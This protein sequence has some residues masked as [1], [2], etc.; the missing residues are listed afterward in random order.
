MCH[1]TKRAKS[2][3]A[4]KHFSILDDEFNRIWATVN[5]PVVEQP[6][7]STEDRSSPMTT[8]QNNDVSE[9]KISVSLDFVIRKHHRQM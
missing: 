3:S 9:S 6:R 4:D 1:R 2:L 5:V 7:N 8:V